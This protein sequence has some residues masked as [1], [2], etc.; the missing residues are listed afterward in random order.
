MKKN[1]IVTTGLID[2]WEFY[3]NNFLLG[4]W[5]EFFGSDDFD[6]EKFKQEIPKKISIIKNTHHWNDLEKQIKDHEYLKGKIEYLLELISEKLST[7]HNVNENKEYWNK[8]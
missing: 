2:T 1:F 6:K 5:C 7:I 8:R 3:E 4:K